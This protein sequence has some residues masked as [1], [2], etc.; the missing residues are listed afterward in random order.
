VAKQ[1]ALV[2]P[3][4]F[5]IEL[6]QWPYKTESVSLKLFKNSDTGVATQ[7]APASINI[8]NHRVT[9]AATQTASISLNLI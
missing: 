2:S 1:R 8:F 5:K 6:Q 9:A 3:K 4:T 7:L